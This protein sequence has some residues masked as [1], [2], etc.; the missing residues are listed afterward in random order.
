MDNTVTLEILKDMKL[1]KLYSI[2]NRKTF[3]KKNS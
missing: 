3:I 2:A 1:G